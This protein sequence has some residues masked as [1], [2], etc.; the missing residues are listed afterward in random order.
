MKKSFIVFCSLFLILSQGFSFEWGG[1][2]NNNSTGVYE[3]KNSLN[4][5]ADFSFNQKNGLYLWLSNPLSEKGNWKLNSEI[6]YIANVKPNDEPVYPTYPLS[7]TIDELNF[8]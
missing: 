6:A 2:L 1:L 7:S 8:K 5:D 3:V 4:E